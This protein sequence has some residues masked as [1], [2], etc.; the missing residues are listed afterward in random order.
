MIMRNKI[1]TILLFVLLCSAISAQSITTL[2]LDLEKRA[3][4]FGLTEERVVNL[5]KISL[6]LSG[7]GSR[8]I[9][10]I[11][12]LKALKEK[13]VPIDM[14]VG[15]SIGSIIG[16]LYSAGYSIAQLDS[17]VKSAD[18]D[19]FF[20][21]EGVDRNELFL[22]QKLTQDKA[23][24]TLRWEGLK[25]ILPT[26]VN[27]GQRVLNF[28][29][30]LS[31]NAPLQVENSFDDLLYNFRAVSTDLISGEKIVLSDGSLSRAMRASSS[32][33]LLLEPL[34]TDSM[35]L[36]DG[37][38]VENIPVATA[39]EIGGDII[40]ACDVTSPLHSKE[41]LS[42][43]WNI[44]DQ[45]IS[46]PTNVLNKQQLTDAD[47]I[48][49]P[50]LEGHEAFDF[51]G[52]NKLIELGY[53]SSYQFADSVKQSIVSKYK[54]RLSDQEI[55]YKNLTLNSHPTQIEKEI[56]AKLLKKERVNQKDLLYELFLLQQTGCYSDL[57]LTLIADS[58]KTI[59][60][61]SAI[62]NPIIKKIYLNGFSAI[63]ETELEKKLA[64]L[65]NKPYNSKQI[66]YALVDVLRLYRD[67]GYSLVKIENV[68]FSE[69]D[70]S[71]TINI[72]EGLISE[73]IIEGNTKTDTEL[74]IR[75]F[76]F[77]PG[78][79]F[80]YKEIETA[81]TNLR[82]SNLFDQIEVDLE[83][84]AKGGILKV[85][86]K[87]K[88]SSLVRVGLRV[89]NENQTQV[90]VD[91]RNENLY[92]TGTELGAIISGGVRN[93]SI[94]LEHKAT[95]VFNTYLTYNLKTFYE[96]QDITTY[97]DD[98]ITTENRF[99]RSEMGEYRQ[100]FFGASF[101]I[102]TQFQKF[103]NI[104]AELKYQK[105]IINSKKD[106]FGPT[107]DID[108]LRFKLSL[109]VDSKNKYPFPTSGLAMNGYYETADG[110]FSN[111]IGY[112]K[113]YF[114][115][116]SYISFNSSNTVSA[117]F[118]VGIGDQTL[119]ISQQYSLGGQ[120]SFFGLREYD[121]RGRQLF[122]G[123]FEYR[124]LLPFKIFFDT[125]IKARY[126][127]GAV[128]ED[129]EQIRFKDLRHGMGLTLSFDSPVGPA[130]FSVGK[131]MIIKKSTLEDIMS[132]GDTLFYFTIG[133]YY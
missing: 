57:S 85:N 108:L 120:N 117:K 71:L 7:G 62:E 115:Y 79:D 70:K 103:G 118:A 43:A 40:I 35:L 76:S 16:G 131:S 23:I 126:D 49:S 60:E 21:S 83:Q 102:G 130:E 46:I 8:G 92:G 42:Y 105:D 86:V 32:V 14:I 116:E 69:E 47:F 24:L 77:K 55:Y 68:F 127:I 12:L 87:E 45:L 36:V 10:H 22:G 100:I 113:F 54:D 31:L 4:P 29:N 59:F 9:A 93:T 110:I 75:D 121:L 89:D 63:A 28:L 73:I 109:S 2:K 56:A 101:G 95:R 98:P 129:R 58:T 128:W 122:V 44:A 133:Y 82:N 26:A 38:S 41:E 74:I 84:D 1:K 48:V 39:R 91:L 64:G 17:I 107:Y 88:V 112:T 96:F 104:I 65:V 52:L 90:S 19:G 124:L 15:T 30:L 132:W 50:D 61:I 114:D 53:N 18:W 6:V 25:P 20:L 97:I 13:D 34:K 119:P 3:L 78:D 67:R 66:L 123:S 37:G 94:I 11:G 106:Y 111:D 51:S 72:Y 99:S 5:P 33:S 125:Y 81:L 27:T 80:N